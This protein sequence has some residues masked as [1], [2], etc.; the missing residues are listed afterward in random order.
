LFS[1]IS[2]QAKEKKTLG[3]RLGQSVNVAGIALFLRIA[4]ADRSLA[5]PH[6]AVPDLRWVDWHAL[7]EA[8]FEGCIFDKDNTLT[9]PYKMDLHPSAAE[10]LAACSAA[11]SGRLALYSNSAGL[12]QY[13]PEGSEASALEV[14][15]GV[16]VLRHKEKKPAGGGADVET[17]FGC[18]SE[19]LVMVG[20]RFL[21][22]VVFGNRC[23]MLTVRPEPFTSKGEPK[24]VKAVRDGSG[25][26]GCSGRL[27]CI[28]SSPC[29]SSLFPFEAF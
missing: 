1:N 24:T 2:P 19:R 13:D 9:E 18:P 22:D 29:L 17:H 15:L 21:T 7:R 16:S 23:G 20:D 25:G 27:L 4:L 8:G 11:F 6:L 3:Q 26:L 14:A 28:C 10:A 12:E 5:V